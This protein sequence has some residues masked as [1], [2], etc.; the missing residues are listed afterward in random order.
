MIDAC[1]LNAKG[2]LELFVQVHKES[3]DFIVEGPYGLAAE[4]MA[5]L[6]KYL[7]A[8]D[9]ELIDESE[10]DSAYTLCLNETRRIL[11]GIPKWPNELF[12]GLLPPDAGLEETAISYTKGC[13]TGQEVISRMK[14]AGKTNKH[15]VRLN[16]DKPLI[17][18]NSKLIVDGK[19]AGWITSVATLESGQDI[20]LGYR[21]RKFKDSNEVEVHSP[22]SDE[23][24]GTAT[25]RTND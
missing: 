12:P 17:P 9:V 10:D 1:L 5:R 8:D 22:S 6:D 19:E 2:Q 4:L 24:I 21:L 14:R 25:V 23:V 20:A 18:T 11:E 3:D 16:L 7:I 13:Y 15:L